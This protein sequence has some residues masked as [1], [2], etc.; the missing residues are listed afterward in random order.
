[1]LRV[2]ETGEES[3]TETRSA[4]DELA[5]EGAR[6]ML[7]EAL[8]TEVAAYVERHRGQRDD[9]GHALVVRNGHGKSRTVTVG[10]GAIALAAPRVNDRRVVDG[11][12]QKFTSEILPPYLRNRPTGDVMGARTGGVT[13]AGAETAVRLAA[14]SSTTTFNVDVV[15]HN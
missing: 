12:R 7:A 1:M 10:A 4:L 13:V 3:K 11:Q 6:R 5:R 14:T 2:V 8:E 9:E 15:F